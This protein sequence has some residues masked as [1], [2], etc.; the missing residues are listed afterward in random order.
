MILIVIATARP[1][2]PTALSYSSSTLV[3]FLANVATKLAPLSSF[4]IGYPSA[5]FTVQPSSLPSGLSLNSTTGV[6]SG[7]ALQLSPVAN[8]TV[9]ASNSAGSVS[10]MMSIGIYGKSSPEHSS[11]ATHY[12][13]T[14]LSQPLCLHPSVCLDES[15]PP[16]PVCAT[17][18]RP[19]SS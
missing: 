16:P 17:R 2:A 18:V 14:L 11:R 7:T 13:E 3:V 6:I 4:G 12:C 10:T 19:T 9:T 1:A 5:T 8:Y 15:Q